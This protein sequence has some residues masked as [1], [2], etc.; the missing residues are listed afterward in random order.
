MP[1]ACGAQYADNVLPHTQTWRGQPGSAHLRPAGPPY[2]QRAS[3]TIWMDEGIDG[4]VVAGAEVT[5]Y[6]GFLRLSRGSDPPWRALISSV[7]AKYTDASANDGRRQRRKV[8]A[9]PLLS[10]YPT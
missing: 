1:G 3:Q 6:A 7:L 8:P 10:I 4:D 2:P 5:D 9:R